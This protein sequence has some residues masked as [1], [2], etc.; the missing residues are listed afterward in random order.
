VRYRLLE[1]LACPACRHENLE[2]E[3]VRTEELATYH[4]S[5]GAAEREQPGLDHDRRKLVDIQE[6]ALHCPQCQGVYP[7]VD[8][9]P[10]M[11][12]E[13]AD[14]G[15]ASGHRWTRFDGREPEYEKNFTDMVLPMTPRDYLGITVLDAGC[16]YG[17]TAFFAARYGAEVVAL[18]L[19][20]DAV[21]SARDNCA[22][23]PRV[24]VVQGDLYD[25]PLKANGFDLVSCLGV[26]HHLERPREAF[27][28]L[29][30]RVRS[31]GSLQTWVYG[32]RAGTVAAATRALRGA[33]TTM[34]DETLH[35]VSRG[36][37]SALRLFSHTPTRL[38]HH[39][40]VFKDLVTHLPA[41]DHHK[42]PFDV[43]VAD[44]FDRLRVPVPH[45]MTGE[46]LERWYADQGFADI[47]VSRRVRNT[48][49]FRGLGVRR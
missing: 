13:G 7:I 16:G 30:R 47:Q 15:P 29:A 1:W 35:G 38:L 44:V 14:T 2:L 36:I 37:S 18:D 5:H 17:R 43:V 24:H 11:L 19:S 12:L 26:L 41:H 31:G 45:Y 10:R 23:M 46:E 6:G 32:P 39:T 33:A 21:A 8:G 40:P 34:D 49:S 3:T 27:E 9:I 25:P 48:E 42:W 28:L 4:A 20:P 22:S